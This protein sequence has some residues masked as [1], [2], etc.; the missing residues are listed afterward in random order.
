[1]ADGGGYSFDEEAL[2]DIA[3]KLRAGADQLSEANQSMVDL[4]DAGASSDIVGAAMADLLMA[5]MRQADSMDLHAGRV[6]SAE[7]SYW[8]IEN[9]AEGEIKKQEKQAGG[10]E[11]MGHRNIPLN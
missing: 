1:M 10:D 4:V 5:S 9:N 11:P 2:G 8:D 6:N 3:N 7:G